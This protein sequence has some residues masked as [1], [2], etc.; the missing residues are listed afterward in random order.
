MESRKREERKGE[1]EGGRGRRKERGKKER[2]I[3][4]LGA[5]Y[6]WPNTMVT[7]GARR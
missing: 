5:R 7:N 6:Y 3:A 1:T 2:Q 4:G